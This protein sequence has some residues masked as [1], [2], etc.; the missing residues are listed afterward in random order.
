MTEKIEEI[1]T[2][3]TGEKIYIYSCYFTFPNDVVVKRSEGREGVYRVFPRKG[4]DFLYIIR[5]FPRPVD[6]QSMED[7]LGKSKEQ[8]V[9]G[10]TLIKKIRYEPS[11]NLWIWMVVRKEKQEYLDFY[12]SCEE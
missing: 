12:L 5:R 8:I 10:N 2:Y 11:G 7:V 3:R 9:R 6:L 4:E 1:K